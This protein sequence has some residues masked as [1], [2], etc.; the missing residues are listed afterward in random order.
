[1]NSIVLMSDK[2]AQCSS[3]QSENQTK[4]KTNPQ[5]SHVWTNISTRK[6]DEKLIRIKT[7]MFMSEVKSMK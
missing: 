7:K 2:R 6:T 4:N 3:F 5:L 1:M